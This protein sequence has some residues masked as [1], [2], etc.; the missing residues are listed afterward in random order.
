MLILVNGSASPEDRIRSYELFAREV[1]P[2]FT[3]ASAPLL[4]AQRSSA[5]RR[6]DGYAKKVDAQTK[7]HETYFGT[8]GEPAKPGDPS[9]ISLL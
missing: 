7:A 5:S 3:G 2:R 4:R 1:A 6:D 9:N 8:A